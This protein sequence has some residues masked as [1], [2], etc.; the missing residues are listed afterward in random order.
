ME[1][2]TT[3]EKTKLGANYN[4]NTK[5][6]DFKLYSKN[7]QKVLLCIFDKPQGEE[8]IMTL[9]MKKG[10]NDIWETSVKDYVL[11]CHQAPV[12]YGFRVFGPN[13]EYVE[14]FELGTDKGFKSKFD[15]NELLEEEVYK[16]IL[17]DKLGLNEGM[18]YE[19]VI[20]QM[21]AANNHRLFFYT[22]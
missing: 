15:E 10:E 2:L 13:W 21:L 9:E 6:V 19:N 7:A 11:N 18:L 14:D 20:A 5:S 22:H 16:Q 4:P 12:F 3:S 8:P 17:N 1:N